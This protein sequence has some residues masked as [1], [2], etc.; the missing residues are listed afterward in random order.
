[1]LTRIA[2]LGIRAPRRILAVVALLLAAAGIAGAPVAGH[3]SAG[4]FSDPAAASTKANDLLASRFHAGDPNLILKV[5]APGGVTTSTARTEGQRLSTELRNQRYASQVASY[6]TAPADVAPGLRSDNGRSGL[7][8]A[9]IAGDDDSAPKRAG[10]IIDRLLK[11]TT[12]GVNVRAGGIATAYHQVTVQVSHDLA[13]AEAVA[14]PLTVLALIWVFG[15]VVAALLPLAVGVVSIVGTLAILRGFALFTHVSIYAMN[16]TTALGLALAIDYSLFI[17]SRYREQTH[18]GMAR[19]EAVRVTMRTAGRTVLFSALTVALSL[20]AMLVFNVYFLRSFAYAGVAVVALAAAAALF[21][22]PALLAILGPRVDALDLRAPVRRWLHRPV[23]QPVPPE[24]TFWG[25][26]AASAMRRAVP[27]GLAVTALLLVLG[28]PFLGIRFGYPDDRV[29]PTSASAHQVGDALR[30]QFSSNPAA[31]ITVVAPDTAKDPTATGR[32]ATTLSRIGGVTGVSAASGTYVAGRQV[33][34]A[35]GMT[36]GHSTYLVV[37]T[38]TEPTSAVGKRVADAVR[39]TPAPWSVLVTGAAAENTDSLH[40]LA[41]R[42]PLAIGLIALATFVVLFLFTGSV[43]L[44][45]KALVLNALSLSATF[46]AMVWIFQ[47]GHLAGLFD[48]TVTGSLVP[49]MP[50]LMFCLAFG[51]SMDYEVFLLS[52]IR[53]EWMA[54]GD[55]VH[56]VTVGLG[57]TGRLV[58]AAALL[59]AIVF[60][61]LATGQVSFMKL[62]GT[63]LTLAVLMDATLVRGVLVPAFMRLAGRANWWAPALLARWH[64]RHGLSESADTRAT[65]TTTRPRVVKT[66]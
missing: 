36:A 40:S 49:T 28:S 18:A 5:T 52:R 35:D 15:S 6:W 9:R 45:L 59:M 62:F 14:V 25:R 30:G 38:K 48:T 3:L 24:R 65:R 43:V 29:L 53:E 32:Y 4:G 31:T 23:P 60:A 61:A 63:G 34:P 51:V 55:N 22:L 20:S 7:V 13:I 17:V 12:P 66:G 1:M 2:N 58:T 44:P 41:A 19:D 50:I 27:V 47:A 10:A 54:T 21:V 57:R 64:E 37:R 42:L 56:A 16:L 11:N 8:V 46:G 39:E 33:G 26:V